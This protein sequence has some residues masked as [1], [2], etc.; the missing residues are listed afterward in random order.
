MYCMLPSR[1]LLNSTRLFLD[2]IFAGGGVSTL[3][4]SRY[5]RPCR[6]LIPERFSAAASLRVVRTVCRCRWR[7]QS[8]SSVW[9]RKR[10]SWACYAT[11]RSRWFFSPAPTNCSSTPA[12]TWTEFYSNTPSTTSLMKAAPTRISSRSDVTDVTINRL[13]IKFR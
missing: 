1:R 13:K 6:C 7:S 5:L 4:T 10:T 12:P 3:K 11:S 8:E 9:W 2:I